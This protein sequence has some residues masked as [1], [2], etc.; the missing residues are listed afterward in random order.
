MSATA[1]PESMLL[2]A[3]RDSLLGKAEELG[4]LVQP[5]LRRDEHPERELEERASRRWDWYRCIEDSV[6]DI[7]NLLPA[8]TEDY[9][10]R[11]LFETLT[12]LRRAI[13]GDPAIT[14]QRGLVSLACVQMLDVL[15]RMCRALEHT[16]LEDPQQAGR[17]LFNRLAALP[18]A[19]LAELLAVSA[20]TIGTWKRGGSIRTHPRR[21][22][23]AAQLCTYLL[24]ATT[25]TGILMW[26][27]TP[28]E[29]L[30]GQSPLELMGQSEPTAATWTQLVDFAR[31]ARGQLAG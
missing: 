12:K 4:A 20:R 2:P 7:A 6:L 30:N 22:Q 1:L 29:V 23:L 5:P 13:E 15:G 3:V 14:D 9:E 18:A 25:P 28:A 21:V 31:G 17:F 24:P 19:E 27:R 8:G 10:A 26:F 11:K 16:E